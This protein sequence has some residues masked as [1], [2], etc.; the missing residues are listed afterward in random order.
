M[1]NQTASSKSIMLNY[2]LYNGLAG[3]LLNVM[4]YALG[5]IYEQPWWVGVIGFVISFALIFMGTKAFRF[6]NNGLLSFGQGLKIGIGIS[7]IGGI[8]SII[9]QQI[10]I[11]FIEPD[12]AKNQMD[13]VKQNMVESNASSEQ[14]EATMQ[15]MEMGQGPLAQIGFGLI[16]VLFIGFIISLITSLILKRDEE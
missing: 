1:E 3:I 14:I 9:Y 2:G 8:I 7:L 10:F 16:A 13:I 12:F 11:N 4:L 6:T 15:M 5:M